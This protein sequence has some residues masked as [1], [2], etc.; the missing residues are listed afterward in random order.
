MLNAREIVITTESNGSPDDTAVGTLELLALTMGG[1]GG[2]SITDEIITSCPWDCGDGD[3]VVGI[4]DFLALLSEWGQIEAACDF[5]GS[6]VGIVEFLAL[7]ANW[8]PCP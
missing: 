6:G 2:F 4:V 1:V 8:G 7:L 5:D 3:G